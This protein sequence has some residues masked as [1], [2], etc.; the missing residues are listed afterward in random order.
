MRYGLKTGTNIDG[1]GTDKYSATHD[2]ASKIARNKPH[3][4]KNYLADYYLN[5]LT[6]SMSN[7]GFQGDDYEESTY[8]GKYFIYHQTV[9][10][11]K[12]ATIPAKTSDGQIPYYV[13]DS[14]GLI[15]PLFAH[16]AS[17]PTPGCAFKSSTDNKTILWEGDL[18]TED[19]KMSFDRSASYPQITL[20]GPAQDSDS[21][22]GNKATLTIHY[23]STSKETFNVYS[24][25]FVDIQAPGGNGAVHHNP[26]GYNSDK[27]G[28]GGGGGAYCR[29]GIDL[30]YDN[31][32][33]G[34]GVSKHVEIK[35]NYAVRAVSVATVGS[36]T[37]TS[38]DTGL[39][40]GYGGN[41]IEGGVG[42]AGGTVAKFGNYNIPNWIKYKGVSGGKGGDGGG[43]NK[44]GN[45]G[46]F[47]SGVKKYAP[48][49]KEAL[50]QSFTLEGGLGGDSD[51]DSCGGGGGGLA[52]L[53]SGGGGNGAGYNN[54]A[55]NNWAGY[56]SS[57]SGDIYGGG[58]GGGHFNNPVFGPG[59]GTNIRKPGNGRPGV[60][61]IYALEYPY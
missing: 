58:G 47:M 28:G 53:C 31:S 3:V 19:S 26:S 59:E 4:I 22:P 18:L 10:G 41:A 12:W 48:M 21:S 46:T 13:K 6:F 32:W 52:V 44:P 50:I 55:N 8:T 34:G 36:D 38:L 30:S 1:K 54:E 25:V 40:I 7:K 9:D 20:Q 42:A 45:P 49:F 57:V 37:S 61:R 15:K 43:D 51:G 60:F 29:I 24:T 35:P 17:I 5:N 56:G 39:Y 14:N 23:S 27:G 2:T 33:F 16:E 11:L